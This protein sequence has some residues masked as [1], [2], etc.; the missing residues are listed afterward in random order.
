MN[1]SVRRF[2][3][4]SALGFLA[5]LVAF[6]FCEAVVRILY[7]AST[8]LFPRYHTDYQYGQYSI[9]G[10]RPNSLFKHTSSDGSWTFQTNNR[11]FRRSADSFY[12]KVPGTYRVFSLGDSHT[13]G[14]EVSQ[15]ATFS[16]VLER[17]LAYNR[18]AAAEVLNAGVSGFSNAEALVLLEN[19]AYKFAPDAVLLGFY[20]NDFVDNVKAGLFELTEDGKLVELK[21]EHLPGVRIQNVIYTIPPVRWLSENSYFY[22]LLFNTVWNTFKAKLAAEAREGR[23]GTGG[24]EYSVSD[25]TK[26]TPRQIDTAIA[27]IERMNRFCL[28]RGI[29]FIVIDIPSGTAPYRFVSSMPRTMQERLQKTGVEILDA[30]SVLA[31]SNGAAEIHRPNGHH[32]ISEFTHSMI[33]I[34]AGRRLLPPN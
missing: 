15:D 18:K 29:R 22:S 31:G 21:K 9:R 1:P 13:Q 6:L 4:N 11:G 7:G 3:A 5:L 8:V 27:L 26:A 17:Y 16:A 14:Y 25:A 30:E 19:E 10:I 32:H 12:E 28:E 34:A 33:G 24:F 2:L 23:A 20:A